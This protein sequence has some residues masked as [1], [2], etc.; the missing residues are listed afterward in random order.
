MAKV[1]EQKSDSVIL[2]DRLEKLK[3]VAKDKQD[4]RTDILTDCTR[5]HK[6]DERDAIAKIATLDASVN[7]LQE[8]KKKLEAE[9]KEKDAYYDER[10]K[11]SKHRL[12]ELYKK[13]EEMEQEFTAM[14]NDIE[15]SMTR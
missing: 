5:Q 11:G 12:D 1:A 8:E 15:H 3:V 2:K 9:L 6:T 13:T 14:L 7:R 4:E 10:I